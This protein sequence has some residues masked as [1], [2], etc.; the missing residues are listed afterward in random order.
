M[1]STTT[2]ICQ[3]RK[4]FLLSLDALVVA[5]PGLSLEGPQPFTGGVN[6]IVGW[7][8]ISRF[9]SHLSPH[10]TRGLVTSRSSREIDKGGN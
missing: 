9:T 7:V 2:I 3:I 10:R 6:I 5:N 8:M 4:L 1:T